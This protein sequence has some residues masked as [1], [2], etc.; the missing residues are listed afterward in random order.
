MHGA[1]NTGCLTFLERT[2]CEM[3]QSI[4]SELPTLRAKFF[5]PVMVTAVKEYHDLD[6]LTFA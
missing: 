5:I 3:L 4:V 1:L 6:G 2:I